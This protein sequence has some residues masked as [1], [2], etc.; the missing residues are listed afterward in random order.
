MVRGAVVF[1]L[2]ALVVSTA[3]AGYFTWS[4]GTV[5]PPMPDGS[6]IYRI[7]VDPDSSQYLYAAALP[8]VSIG[9]QTVEPRG[10]PVVPVSL[11][12]G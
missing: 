3:Q 12:P 8:A 6:W 2:L 11:H 4:L 10:M 7:A 1:V 5:D 9:V